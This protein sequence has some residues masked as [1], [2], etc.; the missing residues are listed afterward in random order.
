[1]SEGFY[2]RRR[3]ILEHLEA[4]KISLLDSGIHDFLNLKMNAVVG[5][6]KGIPPGI[7][8]TSAR[9][10]CAQCPL[11]ANEREVRRSLERLERLGWIKRWQTRGKHGN[12]PIL[13]ARSSVHNPAGIEYRINAAETTDW[14]EPVL[15][16]AA[17]CP[18]GVRDV[19]ADR[20]VRIENREKPKATAPKTTAPADSRFHPLIDAYYE[21]Q[22]K[23]GINPNCDRSDFA[24]LKAWLKRNPNR[25]IGSILASLSNALASSDPYP[26]RPGF[27][28]REFLEHESKYQLGPLARNVRPLQV[29]NPTP[30]PPRS[31]EATKEAKRKLQEY[32]VKGM[33][34]C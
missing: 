11:A 3:G 2:K 25:T 32:G 9:A 14:R 4:G 34:A 27:R 24:S 10:I 23:I 31:Q 13:V 21:E 33:V 30:V 12:Y 22:K 7:V 29:Q 19:S 16:L 26:L 5:S 18:G 1:V 8:F 17:T 6:G 28:L 20:E 15:I